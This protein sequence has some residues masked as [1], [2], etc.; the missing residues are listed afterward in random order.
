MVTIQDVKNFVQG[1]Y[2]YYIQQSLP[3]H[4]EEQAL[5][6]AFLCKPCVENGKCLV[7]NCTTPNMF[8]APQK[9]D[10]LQ[11]WA[12]FLSPS[13]WEALKNHYHLLPEFFS[14]LDELRLHPRSL[15]TESVPVT[16]S[17]QST[18]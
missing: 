1:N 5:L 13:Q 11:R 10:S 17:T 4:E 16:D 8:F 14:Q 9:K 2:K 15:P 12:E 6:R 3:V 7:C 18:T